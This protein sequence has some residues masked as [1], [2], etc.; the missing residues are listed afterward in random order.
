[1]RNQRLNAPQEIP[2]LEPGRSGLCSNAHPH[3]MSVGGTLSPVCV[4]G[5]EVTVNACGVAVTMLQ[6]H[7]WTPTPLNGWRMNVGT[8]P[9][10][11]PCHP[12]RWPVGRPVVG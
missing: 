4:A 1:V 6:G 7:S 12:A 10:A 9:M 3:G 8:I 5:R 2:Q 11:P